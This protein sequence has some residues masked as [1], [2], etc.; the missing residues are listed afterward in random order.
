MIQSS[1]RMTQSSVMTGLFLLKILMHSLMLH[2]N[3]SFVT[4]KKKEEQR[5]EKQQQQQQMNWAMIKMTMQTLMNWAVMM[6][7]RHSLKNRRDLGGR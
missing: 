7:R 6:T 1:V 5:S 4:T 2:C 3:K